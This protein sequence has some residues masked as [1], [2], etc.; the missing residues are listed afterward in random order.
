MNHKELLR[1]A[2]IVLLAGCLPAFLRG[3]AGSGAPRDLS[4]VVGKALV[5]DSPVEV[6]RVSVADPSVVE[7]VGISPLEIVLNGKAPG[8]TTVIVWQ[9]GGNRLLF[10]VN[11]SA[12]ADR[13][14]DRLRKEIARE[15]PDQSV[16]VN[17]DGDTVYLHGTV[18]SLLASDRAAAM[19]A[20]LGKEIRL[21]NL[22]NVT[23]PESEPQ[24]LLKVRFASVD[25]TANKDVGF[26]LF[27]T[28][29]A[30]TIGRTTTSQY[31]PPGLTGVL[32][33][34]GGFT[35]TDAL[36]VFLFRPDLD[37]GATIKALEA[38]K[39]IE[40]LAE[41]NVLASNGKEASFLAGGEYPYPVAQGGLGYTTITIQ[42]REFGVRLNFTPYLTSRGTIRLKVAPEVSALDFANGLT[43]QG[44]NIPALS[45]RKVSTEIELAD[46]QSF[47]IAGL[48]D[49][50]TTELLSKVPGLGD[51]PWLGRFFKSQST[52]KNKS[53]LMI[54]VTPEIVRPIPNGQHAPELSFQGKFIKDGATSVP[55]T[56]GTEVTGSAL[57]GEKR[58]LP[59]ET[60]KEELRIERES[61][62]QAGSGSQ[63]ATSPSATRGMNR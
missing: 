49:N 30:N 11:V 51:I 8:L 16:T 53:E 56:P 58:A 32:G 23:V 29:A 41:P 55:R 13:R 61:D 22:L 34:G 14:L 39:M 1:L 45:S 17:T 42:F 59:V 44:F 3:Q 46:R 10:D 9:K 20:G 52:A 24:I 12:R 5:I 33:N 50:R 27:S 36:N 43:Y 48:L 47:A 18:S 6:E 28:G 15:L 60:L 62:K 35:I 19:A 31:T 21:V 37:L 57:P 54:L 40:M 7:A 25:R 26:N 4:V 38:K 2:L 63:N